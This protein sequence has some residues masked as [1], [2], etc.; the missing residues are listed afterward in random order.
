MSKE[1][2]IISLLKQIDNVLDDADIGGSGNKIRIAKLVI[3]QECIVN[4]TYDFSWIDWNYVKSL[5]N[6]FNGL[7]IDY[8]DVSTWDVSNV[9]SIVG[10]FDST[11]INK[12][13]VG[14][15]NWNITNKLKNMYRFFTIWRKS[16][17]LF[18]LDLRHWDVSN[19]NNMAGAFSNSSLK[20]I[21]IE[22]WN[23]SKVNDFR[24][25]LHTNQSNSL[26]YANLVGISGVSALNVQ[27]FF[28]TGSTVTTLVGDYTIEDV[29]ENNLYILKDVK[30]NY[31][32]RVPLVNRASLRA[33]INGLADLTGK[34]PQTFTIG[35]TNIAKL[36]E[37]DI[38]IAT[39]KN[40]TIA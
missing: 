18:E 34:T 9:I 12:N 29:I 13:I 36:T 23:T 26:I 4:G 35:E 1:N 32:I 21:N 7:I 15:N 6:L 30:V 10:T 17:V 37:E 11:L 2:T 33:C 5:E 24:T 8:I 39:A 20:S 19:V 22:G 40:W 14:I 3:S 38:A 16:P 31:G 28:V 25:F 27:S